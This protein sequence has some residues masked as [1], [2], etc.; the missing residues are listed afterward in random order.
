MYIQ[1]ELTYELVRSECTRP[2]GS[3]RGEI[4]KQVVTMYRNTTEGVYSVKR[5]C[6]TDFSPVTNVSIFQMKTY[7]LCRYECTSPQFGKRKKAEKQVIIV[8]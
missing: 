1:N 7:E 5:Y 4:E 6:C 3:R 2:Q 8:K